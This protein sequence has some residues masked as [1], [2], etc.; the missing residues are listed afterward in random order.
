MQSL[1]VRDARVV[2]L[3][4]PQSATSPL[5]R[6]EH[7][8]VG[9]QPVDIRI[10]LGTIVEVGR[11]LDRSLGEEELDAA[12][13]WAIPGLWDAHVHLQQWAMTVGRLDVS[14]ANAP[15]YVTAKVSAYLETLGTADAS[16]PVV[17]FGYR[18]ANWTRAPT[19]AELDAVTGRLPVALISG[20]LHSAWL[21]TAAQVLCGSEVALGPLVEAEWFRIS[22]HVE[23][24]EPANQ[25]SS[26]MLKRVSADA[27]ARGLVGVS[28]MEFEAGPTVWAD[29]FSDGID[30][31]RVRPAVYPEGLDDVIASQLRSG[32]GIAG[33]DGLATMGP[34][35]V[36]FDGSLNTATA[37]C[38]DPYHHAGGAPG[39][40]G[41]LNY[42][43]DELVQLCGLARQ[44]GL[45]VAVHAIG[46]AAVSTALDAIEA[47]GARGSIE[48]AQLV[49]PR[50]LKRFADLA[51]TA[52]VQP[53]HLLDDRDVT[54][55]LWPDRYERSFALRSLVD[56][57]A[58]L[59]MGSDAP[60]SPLDPWLAMAAAVHRSGDSRPAW[61][62]V[63][64]LTPVQ[65]LAASTDGQRL[66]V[67]ARGDVVLL[68]FDPLALSIDSAQTDTAQAGAHLRSMRA[69]ATI[70]AGRPTHLTF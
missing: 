26:M 31:L 29:H 43:T 55:S 30:L 3:K 42:S 16:R 7:S 9:I 70:L 63:E 50:D 1:L 21:N 45:N 41:V 10:R 66:R 12:G 20:D 68:D 62:P 67:G 27:C 65:A 4:V 36:I 15:E 69:S 53:A 48:H 24:M 5:A 37:H 25:S 60:V 54:D 46:D 61:N 8:I 56:A 44:H 28:D 49:A 59:A 38:W 35:K 6:L 13:R 40:R 51:V 11:D 58:T 39:W 57:G 18:S 47:S 14:D 34:L 17:G 64:S 52:S 33:T 32:E 19:V 23:A 22:A 2:P